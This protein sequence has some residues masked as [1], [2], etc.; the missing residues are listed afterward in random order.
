VPNKKVRHPRRPLG[1]E[2]S[3]LPTLILAKRLDQ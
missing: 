2:T 1:T 3:Y